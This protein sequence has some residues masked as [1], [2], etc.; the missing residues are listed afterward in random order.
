MNFFST[1]LRQRQDLKN[2]NLVFQKQKNKK[3]KSQM[4]KLLDQNSISVAI[5]NNK[6]YWVKDNN[7]Y[8]ASIDAIGEIDTDNAEVVDVFSLSEPEMKNL[9]KILDSITEK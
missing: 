3:K 4:Q 5:V 7:F 9:L 8:T 6:A 2:L 1:N